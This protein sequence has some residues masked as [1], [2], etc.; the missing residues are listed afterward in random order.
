M[1]GSAHRDGDEL[2]KLPQVGELL[3]QEAL[4]GAFEKLPHDIVVDMARQAIDAARERIVKQ[5]ARAPEIAEIAEETLRLTEQLLQP[6]LRRVVNASGVIVHTNLGR[7][8]LAQEAIDAVDDVIRGYSTL[9]YNVQ[10]MERGSR[11]DHC[12]R[13]I[14]ELTGAEA[15]IAVNNNAAAVMMVLAEFAAGGDLFAD[16]LAR[17]NRRDPVPLGNQLRLRA[18]ACSGCSQHD[19]LHFVSSK[20]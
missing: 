9:E 18:F 2:K 8:M 14:C 12:E 6:S 7:S 10:A 17:G 11:H 3:Q 13:L 19:D 16:D 20:C 5:G 1:T 15:A 4:V